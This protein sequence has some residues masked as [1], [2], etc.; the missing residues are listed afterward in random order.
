M[1]EGNI[2]VMYNRSNLKIFTQVSNIMLKI[3]CKSG[4]D[5]QNPCKD[6]SV[7]S[8]TCKK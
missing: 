3:A 8:I 2:S 5:D 6:H 1:V 7:G 4:Q